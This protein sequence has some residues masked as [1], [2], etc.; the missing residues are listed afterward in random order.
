MLA[1]VP[2]ILLSHEPDQLFTGGW[3]PAT[4][5]QDSTISVTLGGPSIRSDPF[6]PLLKRTK[7]ALDHT[8]STGHNQSLDSLADRA[9]GLRHQLTA[10][11]AHR[12]SAR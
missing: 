1:R 2:S 7:G 8:S 6:A 5:D 10:D 4:T 9:S 11:F 3:A 12:P